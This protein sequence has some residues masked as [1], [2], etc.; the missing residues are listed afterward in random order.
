MMADK[1]T[2]ELAKLYD[3]RFRRQQKSNQRY[4]KLLFNDHFMIFLFIAFGAAV[5]LYQRY[6][7]Q[8]L[9]L[10]HSFLSVWLLLALLLLLVG[11]RLG[12]IMTYLEEADRV[13]LIGADGFLVSHYLKKARRQAM[14][15]LFPVQLLFFLAACP[16]FWQAG[17]R[18]TWQLLL[19][20]FLQLSVKAFSIE[21][22]YRRLF[23]QSSNGALTVNWSIAQQQAAEQRNRRDR[24][25]SL[26]AQV[27]QQVAAV[28]RR[29]YLDLLLE[30]LPFSKAPEQQLA[31][32]ILLRYE[33]GLTLVLR[34]WLLVLFLLPLLEKQ[35]AYWPIAFLL[36]FCYLAKRQLWPVF[37][38]AEAILWS[39]LL[40]VS[41]KKRRM[42]FH[43]A[44]NWL[45]FPLFVVLVL[46][47][48]VLI[49]LPAGVAGGILGLLMLQV[50]R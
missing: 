6:D 29:A 19:I 15:W 41:Q 10:F 37:H 7:G 21:Q 47:T 44:M 5:L 18:S 9:R 24:F 27:P 31:L 48:A 2:I 11:L 14:L 25:F 17:V 8:A 43:Q 32:R 30:E 3:Q 33:G 28:K 26:F 38:R 4:L 42:A 22:S 20:L 40:F 46:E 50:F 13:F 1:Q 35:A 36:A 12:R 16:F 23:H 49:S 39:P 45:L 34:Q